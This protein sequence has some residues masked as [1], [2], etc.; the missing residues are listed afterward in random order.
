MS[1]DIQPHSVPYEI[2]DENDLVIVRGVMPRSCFD[3]QAALGV[4]IREAQ[5]TPAVPAPTPQ[6]E[7]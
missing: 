7:N 2:T 5:Q 1:E 4:R 6:G 3:E